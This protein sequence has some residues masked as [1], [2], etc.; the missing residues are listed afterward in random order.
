MKTM[1]GFEILSE[2][3]H[4]QFLHTNLGHG[5]YL[6]IPAIRFTERTSNGD[7][8]EPDPSI[9]MITEDTAKKLAREYDL[10]KNEILSYPADVVQVIC[11]NGKVEWFG[12]H[13]GKG[14]PE[15]IARF[16]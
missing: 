14:I 8:E 3:N 1:T 5:V 9:L 16:A 7:A 10:R 4:G 11:Y 2:K 12:Y 13:C 15:F 6:A